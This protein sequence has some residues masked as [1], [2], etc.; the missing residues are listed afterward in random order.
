M[1]S[2]KNVL[3]LGKVLD[4]IKKERMQED[5]TREVIKDLPQQVESRVNALIDW[6]VEADLQQW[7]AVTSYLAD[8]EREHKDNLIGEGINT[9]FKYDRN[10]L[11]EA[12]GRQADQVVKSYNRKA[13]AQKIAENA[14]NAVATSAAV[15]VGAIGLGTIVTIL[16]TTMAA[17]VTGIV[18][19]GVVAALGLFII[20]ARRRKAKS[21]LHE[22][23]TQL[24]LELVKSL[25]EEFEKEIAASIKRVEEA[26]TPYT[27]FIRSETAHTEK[28]Q[29][30]LK[31]A[32]LEINQI[33]TLIESW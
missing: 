10:R 3:K 27:R 22:K 12:I 17:D 5:F 20:P 8:R 4:L 13:E 14:K 30:E 29:E 33:R 16:A 6:L 31:A 21:E 32:Q 24:R 26:I 23:I 1:N 11:L 19:A 28:I 18:A 25:R 15:E 7:K 2:L 9:N